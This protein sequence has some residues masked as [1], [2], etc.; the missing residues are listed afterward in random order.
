M[1]ISKRCQEAASRVG[2]NE[3]CMVPFRVGSSRRLRVGQSVFA[4][5]SP[6]G[7]GKSLSTGASGGVPRL[8]CH[9]NCRVPPCQQTTRQRLSS[10]IKST[11]MTC[12]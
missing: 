4:I 3:R 9:A 6:F 10:Q 8:S 2:G 5:G 7:Y 1:C 11:N 12:P